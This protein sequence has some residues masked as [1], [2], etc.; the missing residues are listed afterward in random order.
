M[1]RPRRA[2]CSANVERLLPKPCVGAACSARSVAI[3]SGAR[4][5]NAIECINKRG[6]RWTSLNGAL[7]TRT[8]ARSYR[9][10]GPRCDRPESQF[11]PS[12][13]AHVADDAIFRLGNVCGPVSSSAERPLQV[14]L[15]GYWIVPLSRTM[16]V[17]RMSPLAMETDRRRLRGSKVGVAPFAGQLWR[18]LWSRAD[19]VSPGEPLARAPTVP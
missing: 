7:R 8:V 9:D 14:K 19:K 2:Q 13:R 16:T 17:D 12:G 11:S 15:R 6:R 4:L 5:S 3:V 10:G 18:F 1:Q